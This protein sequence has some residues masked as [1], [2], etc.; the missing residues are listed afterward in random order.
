MPATDSYLEKAG[1]WTAQQLYTAVQN[2]VT[3][4]TKAHEDQ[5]RL[6]TRI[7][8]LFTKARQIPDYHGR[9]AALDAAGKLSRKLAKQLLDYKNFVAGWRN[10]MSRVT[11]WLK[12]I[13]LTPPQVQLGD[14]GALPVVPLTIAGAVAIAAA[15]VV[16]MNLTNEAMDKAI[17]AQEQLYGDFMDGQISWEQYQEASHNNMA[18]LEAAAR[19]AAKGTPQGMVEALLPIGL[20]VLAIM[21]LP[22]VLDA[23]PRGATR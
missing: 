17:G 18:A 20:V 14:M 19:A 23:L 7:S 2:V 6:R 10:T 21:V 12:T 3:N 13:G 5:L 11:S 16:S 4:A 8:Q 9:Q 22:R 1:N 15:F